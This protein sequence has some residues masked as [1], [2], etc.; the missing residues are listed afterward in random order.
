[1]K[2][3]AKKKEMDEEDTD[4]QSFYF[5]EIQQKWI[6][7]LQ[8]NVNISFNHVAAID[9]SVR[10]WFISIKWVWFDTVFTETVPTNS[11]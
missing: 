10:I 3:H 6:D 5:S 9:Q 4:T 1:M 7:I 11:Y 8:P 2:N